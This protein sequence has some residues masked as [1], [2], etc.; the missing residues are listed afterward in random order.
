MHTYGLGK[1]MSQLLQLTVDEIRLNLRS[2]TFWLIGTLSMATV[3]VPTVGILLLQ[4]MVINAITRDERAGFCEISLS[5]PCHTTTLFL[6]RALAVFVLLL[7]MWPFMVMA[8]GFLAGM[9]PVEWLFNSKQLALLTLKYITT[10]AT[11]IGF[12]FLAS[13]VSGHAW[14]LYFIA[15]ACWI[16]GVL[17]TSNLSY[18]PTWSVLFVV[19][20][21]EMIPLAPSAAVGY[22]PQQDLLPGFAAFQT[23][24]SILLLSF[25]AACRMAKRGEQVFQSKLLVSLVLA[26]VIIGFT[27]GFTIWQEL[28]YRESGF[29]S[30]FH[31]MERS[32]A[33][34]EKQEVANAPELEAYQLDVKL[35]TASHYLAGTAKLKI[36]LTDHPSGI[37]F[38]T[39]RNCFAVTDVV[40]A[41][42]GEK[43]EWWRAGS[44]LAVRVPQHYRQ[45]ESL[46]LTISYAGQVWE[47]F[48][49]LAA[50]PSGPINFVATP[51][52]LLRSGYA[53]YPIPG[54][55]PLYTREHYAKLWD[56]PPG[57]TLWA[58]RV[59]HPPVPF[60]L[61]VDIDNDN[62]VASN[63][64]QMGMEPLTGEYQ[65]RYRFASRQG[66]DVFLMAGPYH[67]EKRTFPGR[68]GFI[69][70]YCYH[71]HQS[72]IEK[73]LDA[74]A[75]L[76]LFNE[77]MLQQDC[78]ADT[79]I[80][81]SGKICTVVEMPMFCFITEE[82]ER[83]DNLALT[84][85]VLVTENHFKSD[86]WRL[87]M[88][89]EAQASK[90]DFAV[91][92][93]WWQ[94][95][96][97]VSNIRNGN[98]AE[99]LMIYLY[100][101]YGEKTRGSGFYDT[102]KHI[103]LTKGGEEFR[104]LEP[105]ILLWGPVVRDVFMTLDAIRT[106]EGGDLAVKNIARQLYQVHIRKGNIEPADFTQAVEAVLSGADWPQEKSSE[107]RWQTGNIARHYDNP[108]IRKLKPRF[109]VTFFFF[110]PE[111]GL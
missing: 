40:E 63:L 57:T 81:P 22:F 34:A 52:S 91:Q 107:I 44:R 54:D 65:Q 68:E 46:T 58:Q 82:G 53:W 101:L 66:R 7:A 111:E 6:A 70:V 77:D 4:F 43:V 55:Y 31:E 59:I 41:E 16:V 10:C 14:R 24:I 2:K 38:F 9:Q 83:F 15:G 51:Y 19:I 106:S 76:Y 88:V 62:T 30:A 85:T 93:R 105:P 35:R 99:G 80:A 108:A 33:V 74:L 18:F 104:V 71:Q 25:N 90:L 50:R 72:K 98:I 87:A 75:P 89:S 96:L 36:K 3:F 100:T 20:Y 23:A 61:T 95:D 94:D 64:E 26:S 67:H 32:E 103:L 79:D 56:G 5:L 17:F 21:G 92:Q 29:H 73:V 37:M 42:R 48:T 97:T 84:D 109:A 60:Q 27:S 69:E 11:V 47:W 12:V 8:V 28:A 102:I 49:G 45:G 39:L 78:H 1:D 110:Y 86:K 13:S